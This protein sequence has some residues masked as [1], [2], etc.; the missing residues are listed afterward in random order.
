V[1]HTVYGLKALQTE[2]NEHAQISKLL[3]I[4]PRTSGKAVQR[5][6]L[7][8]RMKA[9]FYQDNLYRYKVVTAIIVYRQ[10]HKLSFDEL[11]QFLHACFE[12]KEMS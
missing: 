2:V 1:I 7:R 10:A 9:L 4:T 11:Q 8:R 12:H 3:I 6:R 5:N